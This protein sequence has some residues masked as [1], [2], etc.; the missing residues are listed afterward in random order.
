MHRD[1]MDVHLHKEERAIFQELRRLK[2]C[3]ESYYRQKS[4]EVSVQLGDSNTKFFHNSMKVKRAR[5]KISSLAM[6]DGWT[7]SEAGE[8]TAVMV[9][10]CFKLLG[11]MNIVRAQ[12]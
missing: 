9:E 12:T 7:I 1:P 8:I 5:N 3:E 11:T 10:F 6:E 2:S 4:R